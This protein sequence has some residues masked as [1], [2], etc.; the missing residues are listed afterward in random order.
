MKRQVLLALFLIALGWFIF[1][2]RGI[3]TS[4]FISYIIMAALSPAVDTLKKRGLPNLLAVLIP[5]LSG[6]LIFFVLVFPLIP[7]TAQQ[8]QS[9][10]TNLPIYVDQTAKTLGFGIDAKAIES[11]VSSGLSDVGK[12]AFQVTS[13]VFGGVF[14]LITI[15]IVAF[16]LLLYQR[17]FKHTIANL[18]H[19]DVRGKVYATLTLIDEKL[20]AWLRGQ[21]ILSLFIGTI[22]WIVLTILGV[23][24]AL[25]LA[26]LA[27]I[28]EVIPTLGPTIAAIP[29]FIVA[30]T[31]SPTLGF[32]VV[33]AYI[34]I[35]LIENNI[36]VPKIMERAVGLNPVIVILGVMIGANLMGVTGA[37]L[38][39]PFIALVIV[40]FTSLRKNFDENGD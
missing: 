3:L 37:L 29:A 40:L 32:F 16:Y 34:V 13:K 11:A 31:V 28:L 7:F 6:L 30:F 33:I 15:L 5:Y 9:L 14:S 22:T 10:I 20:G 35:Q 4:V 24:F 17:E 25:P 39:I 26:I 1:Q 21:L 19:R 18:F 8:V 38:A 2:L 27:G 12:N 23:P 36:L